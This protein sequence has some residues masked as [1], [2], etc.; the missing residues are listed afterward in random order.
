MIPNPVPQA[1][2][3]RTFT[4]ADLKS[5][6]DT[7]ALGRLQGLPSLPRLLDMIDSQNRESLALWADLLTAGGTITAAQR[8]ALLGR[9]AETVP[10]PSWPATVPGPSPLETEVGVGSV[11]VPEIEEALL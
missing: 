10:D 3:P 2:V 5:I 9:L 11:D 8:T 7:A 6:L 4:K 1:V